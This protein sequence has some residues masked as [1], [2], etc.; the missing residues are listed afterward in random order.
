MTFTNPLTG[1][2][3]ETMTCIPM[4]VFNGAGWNSS[5]YTALNL[6]ASQGSPTPPVDGFKYD[7]KILK[8]YN[9]S[10]QGVT[11]SYDGVTAQDYLPSKGTMI[12][13][14]QANHKGYG[15]SNNGALYGRQGNIVWG[16]GTPGTNGL[17]IYIS[18]YR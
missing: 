9:D 10:N 4:A 16:I 11:L 13:D 18:G 3:L 15:S 17:N 7:I 2:D 5:T 12:I 14:L 8:I 1:P 6:S